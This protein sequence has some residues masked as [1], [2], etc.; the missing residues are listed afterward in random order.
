MEKYFQKT[1]PSTQ[2]GKVSIILTFLLVSVLT[3]TTWLRGAV[4]EA[5]DPAPWPL[6]TR[7]GWAFLS[8]QM[9]SLLGVV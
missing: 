3:A 2:Q 5:G 8:S 6:S 4:S 9:E 1:N 7:S